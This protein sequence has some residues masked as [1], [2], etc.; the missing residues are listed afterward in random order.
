MIATRYRIIRTGRED[1]VHEVQLPREPGYHLLKQI[2]TPH[3][4]GADL[5]RVA[6]WAAFDDAGQLGALDMFVDDEGLLKGLP[7]NEVA[8]AHYRR[9]NQLDMT[10]APKAPD[11]EMLNFIAGPAILFSRRV[12]F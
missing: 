8:T 6:V 2:I 10:A 5:E 7:R 12:W 1:E 11:I 3:L 4:D 9:A